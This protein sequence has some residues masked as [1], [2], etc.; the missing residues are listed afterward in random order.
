[1]FNINISNF[2]GGEVSKYVNKYNLKNLYY[3]SCRTLKNMILTPWGGLSRRNGSKLI[4][5]LT[6]NKE[7]RIIALEDNNNHIL[8]EIYTLGIRFYLNGEPLLKNGSH[9]SITNN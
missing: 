3:S 8:L 6:H 7:V 1:M 5:N 4:N 2:S 9:Y